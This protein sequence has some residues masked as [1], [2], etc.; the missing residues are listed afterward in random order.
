MYF[1]V[2][3]KENNLSYNEQVSAFTLPSDL[4]DVEAWFK[5]LYMVK[6]SKKIIIMHNL[7]LPYNSERINVSVVSIGYP[8]CIKPRASQWLFPL[9]PSRISLGALLVLSLVIDFIQDERTAVC[10]RCSSV[11]VSF[12]TAPQ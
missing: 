3:L 10:W 6:P 8:P 4:P 7:L 2:L 9:V 5:C 1:L 11:A 12:F